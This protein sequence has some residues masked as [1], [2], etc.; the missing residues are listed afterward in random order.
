[1]AKTRCRECAWFC[2]DFFDQKYEEGKPFCGV[3]G[4]CP[5]DP[6]GEQMNLLGADRTGCDFCPIEKQGLL[7]ENLR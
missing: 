1:M 4:R 7:F 2:Y 5:V 3:H 6:D